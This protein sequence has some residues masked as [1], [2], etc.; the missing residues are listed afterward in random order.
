MKYFEVL[1]ELVRLYLKYLEVLEAWF[2][3]WFE[4]L[5]LDLRSDSTGK[6]SENPRSKIRDFTV[7]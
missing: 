7:S 4:V 3:A 6:F 5:N 2:E 1:E